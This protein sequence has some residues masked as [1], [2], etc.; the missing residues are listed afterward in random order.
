MKFIFCFF[1]LSITSAWAQSAEEYVHLGNVSAK[2]EKYPAAILN[3]TKAIEADP[4]FANAYYNR[5]Y[6]YIKMRKY[7]LAIDDLIKP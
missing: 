3:Y 7:K 2:Q 1:F 4:N 5:G 6:T